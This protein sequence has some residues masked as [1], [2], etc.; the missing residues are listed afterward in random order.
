[1]KKMIMDLSLS[2]LMVRKC[3]GKKPFVCPMRLLTL[4]MHQFNQGE[5][6]LYVA[7]RH[8]R[9]LGAARGAAIGMRLAEPRATRQIDNHDLGVAGTAGVADSESS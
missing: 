2:S 4:K 3:L 5:T 7:S 9:F 1:M 6:V 8:S